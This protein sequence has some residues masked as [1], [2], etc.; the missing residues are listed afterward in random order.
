VV[1]QCGAG[2]HRWQYVHLKIL[3]C[4]AVP[5]GPDVLSDRPLF[6]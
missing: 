2:F 5:S 1:G 6:R 4:F 3:R